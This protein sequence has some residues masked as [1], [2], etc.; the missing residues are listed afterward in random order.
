MPRPGDDGAR[1]GRQPDM[2][3]GAVTDIEDEIAVARFPVADESAAGDGILVDTDGRD[4]DAVF[5]QTLDIEPA[6][7]VVAHARHHGAGMSLAGQLVDEDRRS[8]GGKR[9][10]QLDRLA[11]A[12][13]GMH[14]HDVHYDLADRHYLA[15]HD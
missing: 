12:V 10:D 8:A 11:K 5:A 3:V 6:E 4:V 7:I 1:L 2:P 15:C 9:A 14:G 13:A